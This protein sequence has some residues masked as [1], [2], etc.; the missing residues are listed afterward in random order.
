LID[1]YRYLIANNKIEDFRHYNEANLHV[2]TDIVLQLIKQGVAGWEEFV[3]AEVVTMIKD[4]HLFGYTP[5]TDTAQQVAA[6]E[7]NDGKVT[8][9]KNEA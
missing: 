6:G 9:V 8:I 2:Q 5:V 7:V 1:L 3:P 4:R